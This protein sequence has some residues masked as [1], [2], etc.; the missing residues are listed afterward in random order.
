MSGVSA[1]VLRSAVGSA[2]ARAVSNAGE[3]WSNGR[4]LYDLD[5]PV[6]SEALVRADRQLVAEASRR[7]AGCR[8]A[9]PKS[10][11]HCG[12]RDH[13]RDGKYLAARQ[14]ATREYRG[15]LR[16][17]CRSRGWISRPRA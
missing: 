2:V 11:R 12:A 1:A 14:F 15:S 10:G 16:S 9:S 5:H 3:H 13:S 17:R 6:R 8:H 4:M 7:Y